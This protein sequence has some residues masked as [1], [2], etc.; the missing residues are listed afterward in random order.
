MQALAAV[1]ALLLVQMA[2]TTATRTVCGLI[3]R[4]TTLHTTEPFV[5][6]TVT[7]A[8]RMYALIPAM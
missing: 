1:R 5:L 6:L 3:V 4:L 2:L 7:L 8:P